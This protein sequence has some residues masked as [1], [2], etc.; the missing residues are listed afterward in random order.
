M[1]IDAH[2]HTWRRVNGRVGGGRTRS[3]TYGRVQVGDKPP[4]RLM[5]PFNRVTTFPIEV[6]LEQMDWAGVDKAVLL[7]G[8]FY[9]EENDYVAQAVARHPDRLIG[10]AFIDPRGPEA[11]QELDRLTGDM[12]FRIIKLEMSVGFGFTGLYPDLRLD[13]DEMAW[14]WAA[15]ERQGLVVVL[16]LGAVGSA[17]YQTGAVRQIL[18]RHPGLRIVIA[19]LAQ[20]PIAKADDAELDQLW[21]EQIELGRH[22]NVSFDLS[23]LPAYASKVEDYP[24]ATARRYIARAVGLIGAGK[25][26]W[27]TDVPGLLSQATYPQL[28]E[29]VTRHCN[30]LAPEELEAIVGGN[31]FKLYSHLWHPQEG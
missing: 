1:I 31:A 24:Y 19:H 3:R 7:Q 11:E 4:T 12:S 16:D 9:G 5:P 17:S 23:A 30:F 25:I 29:Y 27:G 15:A 26:L 28:L 20:P 6:L 10:A 8:S 2:A 21:Q 18:E 13:A 14:L 22:P